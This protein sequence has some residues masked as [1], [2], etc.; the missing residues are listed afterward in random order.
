MG[1]MDILG[2]D[3]GKTLDRTQRQ[4]QMGSGD[5]LRRDAGTNSDR[6]GDIFRQ[7]ISTTLNRTQVIIKV[8]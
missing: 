2:Q 7:D 3:A 4:S 1:C 6:G 5:K 8:G